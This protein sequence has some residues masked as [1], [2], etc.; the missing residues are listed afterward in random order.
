MNLC[1]ECGEDFSGV[2]GFDAHRVG[3]HEYTYAEGLRRDPIKEDG[4]RCLSTEE[5]ISGSYGTPKPRVFVR[6]ARGAWTLLSSLE[7]FASPQ[8]EDPSFA[9]MQA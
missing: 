2:S 5:M 4:R 1:R 9:E 7:R 6:S 8:D 3:K